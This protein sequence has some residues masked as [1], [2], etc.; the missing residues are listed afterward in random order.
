MLLTIIGITGLACGFLYLLDRMHQ[1]LDYDMLGFCKFG[2]LGSIVSAGAIW[3][4][5]GA[6]MPAA[7]V[8]AA[9]AVEDVFTGVPQF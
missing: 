9:A 3:A 8:A 4:Y 7:A 5:G 2:M 1:N 6:A